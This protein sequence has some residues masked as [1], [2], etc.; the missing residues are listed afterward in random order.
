MAALDDTGF[1]I[2]HPA[3]HRGEIYHALLAL[4]LL[5]APLAWSAQLLILYAFASNAC[6]P[7]GIASVGTA[8]PAW[9]GWALPLVNLV[10]LL[11]AALAIGL[12]LRNL[13][14]TRGEHERQSG[15]MLDAGE[16]RTRFLSVWGLWAGVIFLLAIGFN[17]LA[18]FWAG[19][20]AL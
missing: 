12:S 18:V 8:G 10:G 11:A 19:R 13:Q 17:T 3:P 2:G 1:D 7:A 14:R 4:G 15:G 6:W 20:C 5:L 16:G 9:L